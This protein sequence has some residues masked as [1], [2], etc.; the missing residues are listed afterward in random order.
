MSLGKIFLSHSSS[1]KEYVGY[2]A[3]K[4]GK[5]RC[6]YDSL[7]F[8]AGMKAL[9]EIYREMDETSIFVVF[10]S[11]ASL[12]SPWV[13][14]ELRV[15][16]ERLHHDQYKLSQCFPIIIDASIAYDDKRIPD[17]MRTGVETYN[18]RYISTP[19][20]AYRKI[21]AQ[22]DRLILG[23]RHN[24]P[25]KCF[26]GRDAEIKK[27]KE[28]FDSGNPIKCAVASGL[29]RM[30]RGS[31]LIQ[32]LKE[33]HIIEKYYTPPMLTLNDFESI[34]DLLVKISQLGFGSYT[35]ENVAPISDITVK[36]QMLSE[37][38]SAIQNY[39]EVLL[40][41]DGK[42]CIVNRFGE[43]VPWLDQAL[44]NIRPEITVLIAAR[45]AVSPTFMRKREYL[46]AIDIT[47]LPKTEWLGLMRTYAKQ[48]GLEVSTEDRNYFTDILS[49]Y[50]P[51]IL[52]TVDLMADQ[53]I[54]TVKNNPHLVIEPFS[55]KVTDVLEAVL[56]S[57][58]KQKAYG[59]LAFL[60]AYGIVPNDL[61]RVVIECD[62]SYKE[63]FRLLKSYTIVRYTGSAMETLEVNALICDYIQRQKYPIPE[64]IQAKLDVRLAEIEK[65]VESGE[66]T[67]A[68]D[69]EE[70]KY[71]L[72]ENIINGS[73]IPDRFMYSTLYLSSVNE[74]YNRQLYKQVISL[75]EKL[76]ENGSFAR[77]DEPVQ[78]LIQRLYCQALA[79]EVSDKFYN[80]VEFF[81]RTGNRRMQEEYNFLRGFMY[82]HIPRY[83]KALESYRKVLDSQPKHRRAKRE[84]VSVYRG[85]EDFE[86]AYSYAK[87]NYLG[88]QEN[89]FQIQPFFEILVRK[90][91]EH[92]V[93]EEKNYIEEMRETVQKI[94]KSKP[95]PTYYEIMA[96]YHA[97]YCK[98]KKAAIGT[99]NDGINKYPDSSYLAK[100]LFDC[101]EHFGDVAGMESSLEKL[102]EFAKLIKTAEVACK[103]RQALLYAYQKKPQGFIENNINQIDGINA[104]AKDR[105]K[106]KVC[107]IL[108]LDSV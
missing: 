72:K 38:L 108:H 57:D 10:I 35:L 70:L 105:L 54:E 16:G 15:A 67:D 60:S 25:Q 103:I 12:D 87:D 81:K 28:A 4:F 53:G 30:G 31:Y 86:N 80:E 90:A 92:L 36:I 32:C 75:V 11:N 20:I 44:S 65:L 58:S 8:E 84:I 95:N 64:D 106:K 77:Y 9:D 91:P 41:Y 73:S 63:T 101:Y 23:T 62:E 34:D 78:E 37:L 59:L 97:Y 46:F 49:G 13:Q 40:I 47:P 107:T 98:E 39:K 22:Q 83:D 24:F 43:L 104:A 7:C 102:K 74:L 79:R 29:P 55:S 2:I 17:W 26:Y 85:L 42:N 48:V 3:K 45:S 76:K 82:R 71:Y 100:C 69:F 5:D 89:I 93:E 6:V 27:F 14:E 66:S 56:P 68:E 99:L 33:S 51:Q 88:D 50:P 61:L 1:D 19:Q 52:F 96:Q 18:L 21:K 94:N